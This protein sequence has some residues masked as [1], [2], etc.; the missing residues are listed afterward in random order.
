MKGK[1]VRAKDAEREG[2]REG[3]GEGAGDLAS[4]W[5]KWQGYMGGWGRKLE[6]FRVRGGVKRA[7]KG[8]GFLLF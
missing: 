1:R 5:L 3:G 4:T 2:E 7:K 8:H 6:K